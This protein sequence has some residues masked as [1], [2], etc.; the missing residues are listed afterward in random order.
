MMPPYRIRLD[1]TNDQHTDLK[2]GDEG[3][4]THEPDPRSTYDTYWVEWDNGSRLG[5]VPSQDRFTILEE[6]V[7]ITGDKE[8][9]S[10][11]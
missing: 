3:T 11:E 1:Y 7:V 6:I 5:L 2:P 4:V 8:V 10:H 9:H